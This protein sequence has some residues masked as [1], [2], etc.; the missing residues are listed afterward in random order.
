MP[1]SAV[2]SPDA[3]TPV[4][5]AGPGSAGMSRASRPCPLMIRLWR[6]GTP[7][8][9]AGGATW[10]RPVA[11]LTSVTRPEGLVTTFGYDLLIPAPGP[12]PETHES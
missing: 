3:T 4:T 11:R 10:L 6:R 8:K 2:P 12:P 9:L 1:V 5:E 7:M